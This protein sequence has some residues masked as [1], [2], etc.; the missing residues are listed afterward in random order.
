LLTLASINVIDI[1]SCEWHFL[2]KLTKSAAEAAADIELGFRCG[3]H[4][5]DPPNVDG[6]RSTQPESPQ[7][8]SRRELLTSAALAFSALAF[9]RG[10]VTAAFAFSRGLVAAALAFSTFAFRRGLVTA[11]LAFSAFAFRRG[12]VTA[13]LAFSAFAFSRG[14]VTAALAFSAFTLGRACIASAF[15]FLTVGNHVAALRRSYRKRIL[16]SI[17]DRR[18]SE[19]YRKGRA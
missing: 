12:L 18:R 3:F 17:D 11:A 9:C 2:G 1:K 8:S 10:L 16:G 15:A 7:T 19:C 13:A 4:E 14:L 5:V 6:A